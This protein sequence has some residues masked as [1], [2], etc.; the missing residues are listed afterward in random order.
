MT[1]EKLGVRISGPAKSITIEVPSYGELI[2]HEFL[3]AESLPRCAAALAHANPDGADE[4]LLEVALLLDTLAGAS[5]N[6][7]HEL[8]RIAREQGLHID[9]VPKPGDLH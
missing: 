9:V 4:G 8:L 6:L 7:L 3:R 2:L 5:R 1:I